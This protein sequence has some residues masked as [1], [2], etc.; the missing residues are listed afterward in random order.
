[1]TTPNELLAK[2]DFFIEKLALDVLAVFLS[3]R[4]WS[5]IERNVPGFRADD[6]LVTL[7]DAGFDGAPDRGTDASFRALRPIVERGI[8]D[9]DPRSNCVLDCRRIRCVIL[10]GSVT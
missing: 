9:I 5:T 8:D 10:I 1:M 6:D 7:D 3:R 4:W 2:H